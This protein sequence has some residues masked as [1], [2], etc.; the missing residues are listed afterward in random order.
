[1]KKVIIVYGSTTGNTEYMADLI[2]K[3]F[4]TAGFAAAS[5]NASDFDP[6]EFQNDLSAVIFGCPAY[7]HDSIELQEDFDEFFEE[8]DSIDL[9]DKSFAVF[10]PGDSSYEY[11]CGSVDMIEEKLESLGAVKLYDGLKIDGDP[12]EFEDEINEWCESVIAAVN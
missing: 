4:I 2:K 10:A 12:E 6:G 8:I 5:V 9:K 7:G 1:M 11:F 3:S